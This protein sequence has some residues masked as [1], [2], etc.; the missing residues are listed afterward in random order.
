MFSLGEM[1]TPKTSQFVVRPWSSNTA[2]ADI[3]GALSGSE[4]PHSATMLAAWGSLRRHAAQVL[5]FG[6]LT[7]VEEKV[8]PATLRCLFGT[9]RVRWGNRLGFSKQMWS[10]ELP[11]PPRPIPKPYRNIVRVNFWGVF[12]CEPCLVEERPNCSHSRQS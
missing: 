4:M 1:R 11:H 9:S 6:S 7:G 3:F 5:P 8:H 10:T 12:L 2:H